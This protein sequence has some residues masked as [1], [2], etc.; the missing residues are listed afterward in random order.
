MPLEDKI[1]TFAR[2]TRRLR[3]YTLS[4]GR[5]GVDSD[6]GIM[7]QTNSGSTRITRTTATTGDYSSRL[8]K[9][10]MV[11]VLTYAYKKAFDSGTYYVGNY[12]SIAN[13]GSYIITE[14][15]SGNSVDATQDDQFVPN[16]AEFAAQDRQV[17]NKI[18]SNIKNQKV[19]LA[20][21]VGERH[22][23]IRMVGDNAKRIANAILA[24][25]KG[26]LVAA[27]KS[28]GANTPGRYARRR[29]S[30][31]KSSADFVSRA[32]LELQYGWKPLLTDIYG[33]A[34]VLA[35]RGFETH[36][37]R[38]DAT[39]RKKFAQ[40]RDG[41]FS[42]DDKAHW[43]AQ[44]TCE[45]F[46]KKVVYFTANTE[47]KPLAALGLTNPAMIAWE[48][49]PWSFVIDWFL[50]VGNWISSWDA[51]LG[52]TF[53]QGS[54]TISTRVVSINRVVS[55]GYAAAYY[56]SQRMTTTFI[57]NRYVLEGFPSSHLP[58][59]K[60]PLSTGHALNA[61]ALVTQLVR[62]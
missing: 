48:L 15:R 17:D 3:I 29:V 26:N 61:I 18:L 12:T 58:E 33:A 24:L 9:H 45:R 62:K 36:L 13:Y 60:N 19:N 20:Q 57:L 10:L 27:A 5:S 47:T 22:Q 51:T 52:C 37:N 34:E 46:C 42:P 31:A 35:S 44:H 28:L 38:V 53:A 7:N 1:V 39:V 21:V 50:P 54:S 4:D 16:S 23:V 49:M 2:A 14:T 55:K 25:K 11:P 32:W 8:H 41:R 30:K 56:T 6:T 59:W 43:Y 40:E